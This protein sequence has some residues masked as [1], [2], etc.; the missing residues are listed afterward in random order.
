MCTNDR[1]DVVVVM[2]PFVAHGHLNQLLHLSR[3]ISAHNLPVHFISTATHLRQLRSR[4]HDFNNSTVNFHEF[5]TP[6]FPSPPPNPSSRFPTHLQ[7]AFES[8]RHL[9]RPVSA[10]ISSLSATARRVAVVHDFLMSYVVQDVKTLPNVET[11]IFNPLS[12]CD[13][14]WRTWER[15]GR[16]FRVDP[17]VLRRLPSE[18]GTFSPEFTDLLTSQLPHI[19]SHLGELFDSSRVIEREYIEYLEREEMNDNKKIWA[20]GPF[21]H[22][23]ISQSKQVVTVSENRH[24]CL[25]WLDLQ[26]ASSVI[27]VSFGTTTT[28]SDEQIKELAIGLERSGQRFIWVTRG[29]DIGD[30]FGAEGKVSDLPVGFE[31]RVGGR[32]LVVRGWAPQTEILGHFAT[33]GFM[34]HCGWNSTTESISMGV[35]VATWPMHSDQPRNAF[36]IT[37]VLRIGLV[38]SDWERRD[39]LVSAAVVEGV[40]R[41]LIDSSEGEEIRKRAAELAEAVRRSVAEGGECRKEADSFINYIKRK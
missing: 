5:Q 19:G 25:R 15:M 16:P 30:I 18:H 20:I 26:P 40:V 6:P 12:A 7:P 37:D 33:G 9:R 28:L 22:V 4:H 38:V 23:D 36:L 13:S 3:L 24:D 8:T 10:L 41:R 29:A 1:N 11:Y 2:V 17:D 32:G 39:E 34:S 14:F 35:P 21:N 27:Y 31:E